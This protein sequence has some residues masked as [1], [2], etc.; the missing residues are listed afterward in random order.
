MRTE[1]IS[2]NAIVHL[3]KMGKL[4]ER[5]HVGASCLVYFHFPLHVVVLVEKINCLKLTDVW[6]TDGRTNERTQSVD[7]ALKGRYKC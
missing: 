4:Y 5:P 2:N 7:K 3:D 6:M 1:S